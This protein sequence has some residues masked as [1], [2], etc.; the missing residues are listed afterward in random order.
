MI[1]AIAAS[2]ALSSGV[3]GSTKRSSLRARAS[4]TIASIAGIVVALSTAALKA[5]FSLAVKS[6]RASITAFAS[7][8]A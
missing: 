5:D 6:G 2:F 8:L 3:V 4:A 7:S 1:S